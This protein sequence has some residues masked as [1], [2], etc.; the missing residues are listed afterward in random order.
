[1]LGAFVTGVLI[2]VGPAVI[3]GILTS[4]GLSGSSFPETDFNLIGI[5]FN[6]IGKALGKW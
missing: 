2:S 4:V 6:F 1:M 5:I 3:Y